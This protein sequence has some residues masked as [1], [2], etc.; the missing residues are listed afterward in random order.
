LYGRNKK[1]RRSDF[2]TVFKTL[3][4]G[5]KQQENIFR[6]MERAKK[7]WMEFVDISL[8]SDEFKDET[9][10]LLQERFLRIRS[11][12]ELLFKNL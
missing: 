12:E 1:L 8:I 3:K 7:K 11:N 4:L 10:A 6:K 2:T 5:T 9:K